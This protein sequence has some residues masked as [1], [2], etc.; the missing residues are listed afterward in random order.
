MVSKKKLARLALGTIAATSLAGITPALAVYQSDGTTVTGGQIN[1]SSSSTTSSTITGGA[2][3]QNTGGSST[4]FGGN[5]G[6]NTTSLFDA[7]ARGFSAQGKEIK[8][9]AWA[10][11]GFSSFDEDQVNIDSDGKVHSFVAGADYRFNRWGLAGLSLGYERVDVDTTF[12]LGKI[13]TNGFV[14]APYA[15]F[16]LIT[17]KLFLDVNGGYAGGNMDT[18]RAS[19]AITGDTDYSRWFAA[20]NLTANLSH[21]QWRFRPGLGVVWSRQEIDAYRESNAN[22]VPKTIDHFGRFRA[23]S[24]LGYQ[25]AKWQPYVLADYEYDFKFDY[26]TLGGGAL[27]PTEHRSGALLGGGVVFNFT[28]RLTGGVQFST[29]AFREDYSQYNATGTIRYAF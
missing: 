8:F 17:G 9:G 19:G 14:V 1:S 11:Y 23:G 7:G 22:N 4:M 2:T 24:Q 12:N 18:E 27:Q 16:Q 6:T 29:R 3:G 20:S 28:N 26:P 21:N 13:E 25:F 15:V 10:Q 5:S